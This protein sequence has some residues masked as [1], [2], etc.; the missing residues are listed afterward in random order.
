LLVYTPRN[1]VPFLQ[2]SF[3]Y[4]TR[5]GLYCTVRSESSIESAYALIVGCVS[6]NSLQQVRKQSH[7]Y[8]M[9]KRCFGCEEFDCWRNE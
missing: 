7:G 8:H 4:R 5:F 2:I 1:N 9:E 3:I 6:R